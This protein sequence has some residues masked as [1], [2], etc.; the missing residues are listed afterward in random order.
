MPV[1]LTWSKVTCLQLSVVLT[2]PQVT[3]HLSAVAGD[4]D[5]A[6][7]HLSAAAGDLDTAPGHPLTCLQLPVHGAV[8]LHQHG[9]RA[10]LEPQ[11]GPVPEQG[12]LQLVQL[13]TLHVQPVPARSAV[14]GHLGAREVR[15]GQQSVLARTAAA[16]GHL[17]R[18]VMSAACTDPARRC[19]PP[20]EG[21]HVTTHMSGQRS[22]PNRNAGLMCTKITL[23]MF[24][25]I[26]LT[27][28]QHHFSGPWRN[29]KFCPLVLTSGVMT[30]L[31]E[32]L[33][34]ECAS[35]VATVC[36]CLSWYIT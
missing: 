32:T 33:H 31:C 26:A 5:L 7:G 3:P 12:A 25:H 35:I 13:V 29:D 17:G 2:R 16:G 30:P 11:L 18:E 15:S 20:G 22:V 23:L 9:E 8:H 19:R 36:S 34:G 10:G 14:G 27:R 6:Q 24:P 4:L 21:G 1:T 28:R